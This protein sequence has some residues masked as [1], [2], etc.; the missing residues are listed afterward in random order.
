MAYQQINTG[1][2]PTIGA[3][4]G[5]DIVNN[6]A[7]EAKYQGGFFTASGTANA[8]VLTS[9]GGITAPASYVT[10]QKFRFV[11]TSTNT[12]ITTLNVDSLGIK[13]LKTISGN[14]LPSGYLPIGQEICA[15]YDGVNITVCPPVVENSGRNLLING[16]FSVNQEEVSGTVS[17][18]AGE[19]GHDMWK[20]GSSGCTYTFATAAGVTT[21]TITAGT[22]LQI[23]EATYLSASAVILSWAGTSTGRIDSGSYGESGT[24]TDTTAGGANVTAEFTT[25]TLSHVQLERGVTATAFEYVNPADQLARCQRYYVRF[26]EVEVAG[27]IGSVFTTN[28]GFS[29]LSL[30]VEL[31]A[32]PA[33]SYSAVADFDY[34]QNG[35]VVTGASSVTIS[36]NGTKTVELGH[37]A[38]LTAGQ[39]FILKIPAG[40]VALDARL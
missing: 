5:G 29:V 35:A 10:G 11:V 8:I 30:P 17:L 6:N 1:G 21:I 33:L 4:A 37:I 24:V 13:T 12:G 7:T 40:W 22:L 27:G 26:E 18:T 36:T 28:V 14:D 39:P 25:G 16:D 38:T 15:Y 19:Y 31:R 20:A 23:V 32:L 9:E 3:K 34:F 2:S